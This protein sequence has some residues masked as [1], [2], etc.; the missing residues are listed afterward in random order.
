MRKMRALSDRAS[1]GS[2]PRNQVDAVDVLALR[3]GSGQIHHVEG[4]SPRVRVAPQL[5]LLAAYEPVDAQQQYVHGFSSL[6]VIPR[7]AY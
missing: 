7:L 4:L 6:Q 5:K 3:Q 2:A 1:M